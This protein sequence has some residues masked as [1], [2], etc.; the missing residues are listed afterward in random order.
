MDERLNHYAYV[1]RKSRSTIIEEAL[2]HYL[3]GS[4]KD[5]PPSTDTTVSRLE[6]R[7]AKIESLIQ[8]GEIKER[9]NRICSQSIPEQPDS[10]SRTL[11]EKTKP[12]RSGTDTGPSPHTNPDHQTIISLDPDGW[13]TQTLVG[14][15]LD[16]SILLSTRKSIVSIAVARGE[17]ETNGKKRKGCRIKGSSAI[18]WITA[19]KRKEKPP[20]FFLGSS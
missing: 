20:V 4:V 11:P 14:E 1:S 17:M 9:N 15:F 19:M 13:Y 5:N 12:L 6:E 8:N 16:P 2:D 18:A 10:T 3:S 7:I